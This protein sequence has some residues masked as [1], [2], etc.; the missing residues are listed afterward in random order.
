M[1]ETAR[2]SGWLTPHRLLRALVV[3][4]LSLAILPTG[5]LAQNDGDGAAILTGRINLTADDLATYSEPYI[6]LSDVSV[7]DPNSDVIAG[8][9]T[10]PS[11][12]S[13]I[14]TGLVAE[15]NGRYSFSLSLPISP[16]GEPTSVTGADADA[17]ALPQVFSLDIVSNTA[18]TPFLTDVDGYDGSA[19]LISSVDLNDAGGATGQLAVWSD[20]DGAQFHS[21][22][23]GEGEQLAGEPGAALGRSESGFGQLAHPLRIVAAPADQVETANHGAKQV[24]EVMRDAAG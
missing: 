6:I 23:A 22:R 5:V 24:V 16:Q 7:L 2:S 8:G 14:A 3:L 18:G 19:A 11:I 13:Q 10:L 17:N 15:G 12:P 4:L 1:T 21:L 20:G 9:A